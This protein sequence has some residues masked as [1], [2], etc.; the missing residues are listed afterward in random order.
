METLV[1]YEL[2]VPHTV[3]EVVVAELEKYHQR[4]L[5][6][7]IDIRA[8][9]EFRIPGLITIENL[10]VIRAYSDEKILN[11]RYEVPTVRTAEGDFP[12]RFDQ[13][14]HH[15]YLSKITIEAYQVIKL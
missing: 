11:P 7:T 14:S 15:P 10:K 9:T 12:G 3:A 5:R 6:P 8:P 4:M 1:I 2:V 13:D